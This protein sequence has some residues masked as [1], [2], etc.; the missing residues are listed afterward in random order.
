MDRDYPPEAV[1]SESEAEDEV[2]VAWR[3]LSSTTEHPI[4]AA[5]PK[6]GGGG[7]GEGKGKNK[8]KKGKDKF[9]RSGPGPWPFRKRVIRADW[10][11]ERMT[12]RQE[13]ISTGKTEFS[14][15]QLLRCT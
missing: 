12:L 10:H 13:Q 4:T 5:F 14:G 15:T 8:G 2:T 3:A 6:W 11:I 9:D 1:D 7:K